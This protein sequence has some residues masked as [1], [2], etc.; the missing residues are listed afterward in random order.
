MSKIKTRIYFLFLINLPLI[1]FCQNSICD[2]CIWSGNQ[3]T[4]KAPGSCSDK[5]KPNMFS[6]MCYY[7]DNGGDA[8]K[9]FYQINES[10]KTCQA[11]STCTKIIYGSNQCVESC[12]N[13]YSL[14]SYCYPSCTGNMVIKDE[15]NRECK[16]I[17]LYYIERN[18]GITLYHCSGENDKCQSYDLETKECSQS[19]SC[20]NGKK[21]KETEGIIRCSDTCEENEFVDG[22]KCL[23][24]CPDSKKHYY[25]DDEGQKV[26]TSDCSE[27]SLYYKDKKEECLSSYECN[28]IINS[29]RTCY[30]SCLH[31][32]GSKECV[33]N[34][35]DAHPYKDEENQICYE[36]CPS[37][38]RKNEGQNN[39]CLKVN[40]TENCFFT[41]TSE[42]DLDKICYEN[43]CPEG[44]SQIYNTKRCIENCE[45]DPYYKYSF[46]DEKICYS[47]CGSIPFIGKN[48]Y[49]NGNKCKCF[50]Y[51]KFD[52]GTY[53]CYD[54]ETTSYDDGFKF[55]QGNQF[56]KE[57][58][59]EQYKY[60]V[61]KEEGEKLLDECF[62]NTDKCQ[63]RNYNYFNVN[64]KKCYANLPDGAHPNE[65]DPLTNKPHKDTQGNTYYNPGCGEE[66]KY[67]TISGVCKKD[68]CDDNEYYTAT[69]ADTSTH[70]FFTCKLCNA[71]NEFISEDRKKCEASCPHYYYIDELDNKK[72]C[73]SNCKDK[74]KFFYNNENNDNKCYDSCTIIHNGDINYHFYNPDNNECLTTCKNNNNNK[75]YAYPYDQNNN[76]PQKCISKPE[77]K[78]YNE[79][80]IIVGNECELYS[81]A[82]P[83]LCVENC[84]GKKVFNN[85]C[86][87]NCPDLEGP[88]IVATTS[89][90]KS[91]NKCVTECDNDNVIE[92]FTNQCLQ[93]CN[94][95]TYEDKCYPTCNNAN[96][97]YN[98]V[99][100]RCEACTIYEKIIVGE[101]EIK[102]CKSKCEGEKKY[103]KNS[104]DKECVK[105][106]EETYNIIGL[107]HICTNQC[108]SDEFKIEAIKQ[109]TGLSYKIYK[110]VKLCP[111]ENKYF[112][113][114]SE[115]VKKFPGALPHFIIEN[116]FKSISGC[117]AEYPYYYKDEVNTEFN[118]YTCTKRFK[119]GTGQYAPYYCDGE[120]KSG[121]DLK[122]NGYDYIENNL[123]KTTVCTSPLKKQRENYNDNDIIICKA[124]C[125]PNEYIKLDDN[126]E[127]VNKCPNGKYIGLN[128]KC[129]DSCGTNGDPIYFYPFDSEN[130]IYKCVDKCPEDYPYSDDNHKCHESCPDTTYFSKEENH[131]YNSCPSTSFNK[132]SLEVKDTNGKILAKRCLSTC[133]APDYYQYKYLQDNKCQDKCDT[134]NY[135]IEISN[136]CTTSCQS[137]VYYN[138]ED[139]SITNGAQNKF[140]VKHCPL[141]TFRDGNNCVSSCNSD[142]NSLNKFYVKEFKHGEEIL[143][144][145]CLPS[146]PEEYPFYNE[147]GN[148]NECVEKCDDGYYYTKNIKDTTKINNKCLP[149]CLHTNADYK[150][151]IENEESRICYDACPEEK[152]FHK[153][154]DEDNNCY[155]KCPPDAP[156]HENV[157]ESDDNYYIC[158]NY[159]N[160]NKGWADF[161]TKECLQNNGCP[162]SRKESIYNGKH[163]CLDEC[164][165]PYGQ[166]STDYNGCVNDCEN[167]ELVQNKY[168]KKD[169]YNPRC[170]CN[171]LYYRDNGEIKCFSNSDILECRYMDTYKINLY[172]TKECL[173]SCNSIGVLSPTGDI[174]HPIPYNCEDYANT[175]KDNNKCECLDRSYINSNGIKVCLKVGEIC[176]KGYEN[177]YVPDIKL[178]LKNTDPCPSLYNKL[179]LG[180]YC[181]KNCPTGSTGNTY[182]PCSKYW[183]I[184]D[185]GEFQCKTECSLYIPSE[186][187]QCVPKCEGQYSYYYDHECYSSCDSDLVDIRIKNAIDV[188]VSDF[189]LS[190]YKCECKKE[191]FWYIKDNIKYCV[192]D[193]FSSESIKNRDPFKFVIKSTSECVDECLPPRYFFNNECFSSCEE[194]ARA[195]YHLTVKTDTTDTTNNEC[196]CDYLWYYTDI[197][198]K[199]KECVNENFCIL[200]NTPEIFFSET[201]K[202]VERC[203]FIDKKGFNYL[204]YDACPQN[205]TEKEY[206]KFDCFCDLSLGYW[207]EYEQY[208]NTYISCALNE[209][210]IFHNYTDDSTYVRMNLIESEKKC[211]KSCRD[212]DPS[213]RNVFA[214]R[215]IC[216]ESCPDYTYLNDE[217]DE[218][219]FFDL[220]DTR[221]D[222]LDKFKRAANVQAKELYENSQNLGGFLYNKFNTTLEIYAIDINNSLKDISFKSNLTYID[223]GTCL[224]KMYEHNKEYLRKNLTILV[225][226]YD[227]LP[228][229]NINI[230]KGS[231]DSDKYFINPVEYEFF[232]SNMSEK[233]DASVCSPYEL[234]ISYPLLISKFD[235]YDGDINK[236]EL[237][238]RFEIGK[239]LHHMDNEIDTFNYNNTIYKSFCRGLEING[240]DLLYE[241]RYKYLYPNNKLLC[242]SNCTMNNTDFELERVTC[243]CSYKN[244]IDF[245]RIE[246]ETN[247]ILNDPSFNLPTQSSVNVEV[248]KCLFN[249]TLKQVTIYNGAFYYC[250]VSLLVQISMVIVS[251]TY[252]IKS[253]LANVRHLLNRLNFKDNKIGRRIQFKE[254]NFNNDKI[255]TTNRPLNHPPRK[256]NVNEKY[257][258]DIDLDRNIE[259]GEVNNTI[260][261]NDLES[262]GGGN[263]EINLKKGNKENKKN[264]LLDS[265]ESINNMK[266]EYIPP[267]YNFKFFKPSDRGV[268]KKIDRSKI[269]FEINPNTKYLIERKKGIEYPDNYLNGPYFQEQN[270][271]IITDEKN[272]DV[273][274]V[275][276]YIKNEKLLKNKTKPEN[277]KNDDNINNKDENKVDYNAKKRSNLF[278]DNNGLSDKGEKDLIAIKKINQNNNNEYDEES[279]LREFDEKDDLKVKVGELG[280]LSSIKRE[281]ALLRV[282]YEKYLENQ[283]SDIFCVYLAEILDKIYFVKICIF[284]KKID[285]FSI[286]L[287]LYMFCH[288]LLLSLLCG[289]FSTKLIKKIWEED[290]FPDF[291]FYVLYG[292]IINIIVWIIYQ[293]FLC[294]LDNRDKVKV[295]IISKNELAKAEKKGQENA[296]EINYNIFRDKFNSY[297]TQMKCKIVVFYI[298]V[299][300][301]TFSLTIYLISFF[302]LYTGTKRRALKAYYI[303]I[304]EMLLIKFVYGFILCSLR[305]ASK[306][307]RIRCLYNI[308]CFLNKYV[309]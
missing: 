240:K 100:L 268:I 177:K 206:K 149:N 11:K 264:P 273:N 81:L 303:S 106:C 130:N 116:E 279:L 8:T 146:C 132:Y 87:E 156:Y 223:F 295:L 159:N 271:V 298:I 58:T 285:I 155:V 13:Y 50:F 182:N 17:D 282:N 278:G 22:N 4:D 109:P 126:N 243:L 230:E 192:P 251:A 49:T 195:K 83:Q 10:T 188:I 5:C 93:T 141:A 217:N 168:L 169:P 21:M 232:S 263:Y 221:L 42:F 291:N 178:C 246:K 162:G 250:A 15:A 304:I 284:L 220:N 287:S 104:Q 32:Y 18:N 219:L 301:F 110:C 204:C 235:T 134:D 142:S 31:N 78:C 211:V 244:G 36:H 276:N 241:D 47:S 242:E 187:N 75:K 79:D 107:D 256:N 215:A 91:I 148:V 233:L 128:N 80:F 9:T 39:T 30:D 254:N 227:L 179:F 122:T 118:Y 191:E 127:C 270:I 214:L 46:E 144:K 97:R 38:Y 140:C 54:N 173:L 152:P 33:E 202:C 180:K 88:Y 297:K 68:N 12:G 174:C 103:I 189:D 286:H 302:S 272:N 69:T 210:P 290:N 117:P 96:E 203:S 269:P 65:I 294:L 37:K 252:G 29:N 309:S 151:K 172:G 48:Y 216:I 165:L 222:T 253:A 292:L 90:G 167:D 41:N 209:C 35:D 261:E 16:C 197:D 238:K 138:Y 288:L 196:Q 247:D 57:C 135:A 190:K 40:D 129:R 120:C 7:C 200:S 154:N 101:S 153:E 71:N 226:K 14:G 307:S 163:I 259:N 184:N 218:C 121:N 299:F 300:L 281:Q 119:C 198:K 25:I 125:A 133:N 74:G 267:E 85:R 63:E 266:V 176:P 170:I 44:Y 308:I 59:G 26:C 124:E 137:P 175:S 224:N 2:A 201:N 212:G 99:A 207:L 293:I 89:S 289:I 84:D 61:E 23:T 108:N 164:M 73:V 3:C 95:I 43:R 161:V 231:S 51:G 145:V 115:C 274:K 275:L 239:E 19:N 160:C 186:H 150:Y 229:A 265:K 45:N 24:K 166:Y 236:N 77:G 277:N 86:V 248:V 94:G 98:P 111:T 76:I 70:T 199:Y 6:K 27:K 147:I 205:T 34:C 64:D 283:H 171:N 258:E 237:R 102:I 249:F 296:S 306:V 305:L 105:V 123:C 112:Y 114:E 185:N 53:R 136:V 157:E 62:E 225:A 82:D 55:K 213:N 280:L 139:I 262:N 255:M 208:G 67:L 52:N 158:K 183:I 1:T 260:L 113:Y 92:A 72:K 143:E 66:Y 234:I 245:N 28:Y 20:S 194:E 131:C 193:C 60:T 228:D 56:I 181:L 257:N